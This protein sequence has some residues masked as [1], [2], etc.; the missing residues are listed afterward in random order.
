[1]IPCYRCPSREICKYLCPEAE[2]FAA[3]D[4]VKLKEKPIGIPMY[5]R[6]FEHLKENFFLTPRERQVFWLWNGG[7]N[8]REISQAL[9]ISR[10]SVKFHFR[11][12]NSKLSVRVE[13]S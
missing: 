4:E 11:N 5:G 7:L 12:L 8:R 1:M 9:N 13:T 3:K 10:N 2:V 6:Y